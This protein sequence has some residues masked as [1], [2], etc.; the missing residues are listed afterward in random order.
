[1]ARLNW[2]QCPAV[3][4]N[5]GTFAL[6]EAVAVGDV[7]INEVLYDPVVGGGDFVELYNRSAKTLSLAGW[8][9]A[10]VTSGVVS[11]PLTITG[12]SFILLPGEYA[13]ICEDG[14]NLISLYPQSH[15]DRFV[16]TDMPSYNNGEGSVVLHGPDGTQLDRFDYTDNLHFALVNAPEG[17]SLE[18]L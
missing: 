13:L 6:P 9:L 17:Y 16:V 18:R 2:A 12:A 11:S 14:P 1:M 15:A 5:T 8:K 7:V 3:E 10:N 4:S